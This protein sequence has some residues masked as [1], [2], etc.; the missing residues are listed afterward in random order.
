MA[1]IAHL[2]RFTIALLVALMAIAATVGSAFAAPGPGN[3]PPANPAGL[4]R[5][6]REQQARL[7]LQDLRLKHAAEFAGKVE[8][9]VAKLKAQGKDTAALERALAEYRA[10]IERA[11]SEWQAAAATLAKHA[12]FG[13]DGKVTNADQAR[14][15]LKDAHGHMEQTH[16]IAHEAFVALRKAMAEFRKAN[17]GTPELPQPQEP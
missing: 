17:R 5:A 16:K 3:Q 8:A 12:G 4:T 7:K 15:T 13:D 9:M 14:A 10:A 1:P 2:R 11:R 6:Y